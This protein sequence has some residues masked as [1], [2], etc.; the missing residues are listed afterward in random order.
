MSRPWRTSTKKEVVVLKGTNTVWLTW[1]T[2]FISPL[3]YKWVLCCIMFV[4]ESWNLWNLLLKLKWTVFINLAPFY[5]ILFYSILFYS[6]LFY[7]ILFYS[8]LFYSILFYSILFYSILFYSILFYS[9]LFYSILFYSILFYSILF[10]SILFYSIL[11]YSILFYSILFC[12]VP[13]R[14]VP[15]H[16]TPLHSILFYFIAKYERVVVKVVLPLN[17]FFRPDSLCRFS[18]SVLA[19][20]MTGK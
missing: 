12:S 10:Y 11:F 16:S 15:L 1:N 17:I 3:Q 20:S 18:L 8:I 9:I 7:S 5:S 19:T 2:V 4:L 14:S 6:I 13:F